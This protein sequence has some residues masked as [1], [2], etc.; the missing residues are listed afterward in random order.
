MADTSTTYE[1]GKLYDLDLAQL[2]TDP[3]QPRKHM[4]PQALGS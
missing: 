4:N 1:K 2:R 3:S